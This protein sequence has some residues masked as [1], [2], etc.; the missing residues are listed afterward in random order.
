[1]IIVRVDVCPIFNGLSTLLTTKLRDWEPSDVKVT[2]N[3]LIVH[4]GTQELKESED[5]K[6]VG[7]LIVKRESLL[8]GFD[9]WIKNV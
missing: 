4:E 2:D 8:I 5:E 3:E 9:N 6:M 7:K 1:M